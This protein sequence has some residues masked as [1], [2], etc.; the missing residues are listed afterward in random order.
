MDDTAH[1]NAPAAPSLAWNVSSPQGCCRDL[2]AENLLAG[3]GDHV[4]NMGQCDRCKPLSSPGFRRSGLSRFSLW[5]TSAIAAV[6]EKGFNHPFT[7][8][9]YEKTYLNWMD[10]IHDWCICRQLWWGHRIPAW[11]CAKCNK[12][13]VPR[14]DPTRCAIAAGQITQET[15][16]L[17]TWFSSGLLP[18]SVFGWPDSPNP[19]ISTPSIRP[20]CW[21]P[22]STSSS[23]GWRA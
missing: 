1:M 3:M 21:S 14:P 10:N 19:Q 7:P 13:T 18:V 16:V 8:E 20:A 12:I 23:S 17:D 9:M 2:E 22:A 15:D 11:H 5:P 6:T 4:N